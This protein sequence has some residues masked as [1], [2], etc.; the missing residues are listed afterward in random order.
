MGV[1]GWI[2]AFVGV[3]GFIHNGGTTVR[4]S[5]GASWMSPAARRFW[6]VVVVLFGGALIVGSLAL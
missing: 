4:L 3:W 5:G 6:A 2:I 1:A